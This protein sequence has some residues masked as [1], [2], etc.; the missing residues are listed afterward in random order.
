VGPAQ[1][2]YA[3]RKVGVQLARKK[4]ASVGSIP[5]LCPRISITDQNRL[6]M[7]MQT[8]TYQQ[9]TLYYPYGGLM[10]E[11]I[12]AEKNLD[13]S[14]YLFSRILFP[15]LLFIL[16]IIPIFSQNRVIQGKVIDEME[17]QPIIGAHII[18]NDSIK[19]GETGID[20]CFQF[21]TPLSI[22]K[23]SFQYFGMEDA[24]LKLSDN[25]NYIELIM[26]YMP[27][28]DFMSFRKINK[29]RKR[30]YKNLPTLHNKAYKEGVFL[31]PDVCYIQVFSEMNSRDGES[32]TE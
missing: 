4:L 1:H 19:V 18:I 15:F 24:D 6:P 16:S 32:G 28:Y 29:I 22:N 17:R 10:V 30:R 8:S 31:F 25:C 27:T 2:G 21:E 3:I 9:E 5:Y 20:G 11:S 23:L 12:M 26:I 7:Y 13:V 14:S